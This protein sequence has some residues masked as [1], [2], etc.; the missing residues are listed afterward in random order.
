MV[1]QQ[2]ILREDTISF[3]EWRDQQEFEYQR[4][5]SEVVDYLN[6][7]LEYDTIDMIIEQVGEADVEWEESLHEASGMSR[8]SDNFETAR[9]HITAYIS[10]QENNVNDNE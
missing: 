4:V 8:D 6:E 2:S 10:A 1:Q 7:F 9:T 3:A 5:N